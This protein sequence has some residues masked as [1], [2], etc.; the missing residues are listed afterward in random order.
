MKSS[1]FLGGLLVGVFAAM[2]ASR[3]KQSLMSVMSGAGS[4]LK[5]AGISSKRTDSPTEDISAALKTEDTASASVTKAKGADNAQVYPSS[6]TVSAAGSNHSKEYSLKQLTD[7]IKGDPDVR[8]EV[9][10]ILKE[11]KTPVPGL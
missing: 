9:E 1:S 4:V 5:F 2:W 11:A 10:A 3:R 6:G 8:R 7:L